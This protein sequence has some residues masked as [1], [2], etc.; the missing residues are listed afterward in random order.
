MYRISRLSTHAEWLLVSSE[1]KEEGLGWKRAILVFVPGALLSIGALI[2]YIEDSQILS[3]DALF[4]TFFL[5]LLSWSF[6]ALHVPPVRGHRGV[7]LAARTAFVLSFLGYAATFFLDIG[8]T[9]GGSLLLSLETDP[10]LW[11]LGLAMLALLLV[12]NYVQNRRR[13]RRSSRSAL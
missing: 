11:A 1:P 13:A 2:E 10:F 9:V 8:V 5:V 3:P 7:S 4:Q 12:A 6:A